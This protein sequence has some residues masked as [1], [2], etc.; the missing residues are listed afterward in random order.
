[1]AASFNFSQLL[2]EYAQLHNI[3]DLQLQ[4]GDNVALYSPLVDLN[5]AYLKQN[6][7][8]VVVSYLGTITTEHRE[9]LLYKLLNANFCLHKLNIGALGISESDEVSINVKESVENMNCEIFDQLLKKVI[10]ESLAWKSTLKEL[11]SKKIK[12]ETTTP[13]KNLLKI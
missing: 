12:Q 6:N 7:K 5:I 13:D 8:I 3:P 9:E 1:M 10:K 4:Q 2:A 11:N